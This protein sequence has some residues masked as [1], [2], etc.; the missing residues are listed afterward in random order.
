MKPSRKGKVIAEG[1]TLR[2]VSDNNSS[3]KG[4]RK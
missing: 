2:S 4:M 3:I 1:V